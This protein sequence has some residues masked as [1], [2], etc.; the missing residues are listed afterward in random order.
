MINK[1]TGVPIWFS[2]R[3]TKAGLVQGSF[4]LVTLSAA[5]QTSDTATRFAPWHINFTI[6]H[7]MFVAIV[8]YLLVLECNLNLFNQ[9]TKPYLALQ[10]LD[11][12]KQGSQIRKSASSF[13]C[14]NIDST[15]KILWR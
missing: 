9:S 12:T 4:A 5:E 11:Y 13:R 7:P 2:G 8:G 3:S 1:Y 10:T 15:V 6:L 14:L